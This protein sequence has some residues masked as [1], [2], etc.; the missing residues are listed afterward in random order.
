MIELFI[1]SSTRLKKSKHFIFSRL[2]R[3][4]L[5]KFS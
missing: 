1:Q 2:K 3:L 5:V 4:I